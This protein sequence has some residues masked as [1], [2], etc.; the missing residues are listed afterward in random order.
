MMPNVNPRMLKQAMKKMGVQQE[1]LEAHKVIIET[2]EGNYIIND[3]GVQKVKM[4]GQ[5]TFQI[6]GEAEFIPTKKYSKEDVKMVA[7][8]TG[9]SEEQ[10][11][12]MLDKTEGDIA[13]AIIKL[14]E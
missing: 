7:E 9:C 3:P 12:E 13:E 8:Q 10:A 1:D 6:T 11:E 14:Q 2:S 4:M 5:E